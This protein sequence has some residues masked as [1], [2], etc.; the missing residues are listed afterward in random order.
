MKD[1]EKTLRRYILAL[2]LGFIIL[3]LG[4]IF[5]GQYKTKQYWDVLS[6]SADTLPA[7][8]DTL[9]MPEI[10][11]FVSK[12]SFEEQVLRVKKRIDFYKVI[13]VGGQY[14]AA[15]GGLALLVWLILSRKIVR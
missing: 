2:A 1:R 15:S 14:L 3:G 4:N 5:Y 6:F 10:S 7:T 12:E 8:E 11:K 13:I 9:S